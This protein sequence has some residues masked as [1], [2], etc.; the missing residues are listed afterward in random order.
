MG[1]MGHVGILEEVDDSSISE[2]L[3]VEVVHNCVH[4]FLATEFVE[5]S[6]IH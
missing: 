4:V 5:E 6:L 3:G 2:D 1:L